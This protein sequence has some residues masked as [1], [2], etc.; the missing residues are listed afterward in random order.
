[1][2]I[3]ITW[4]SS[5]IGKHLYSG[6]KNENEVFWISRTN[7]D[8]NSFVW[9]INDYDFLDEV[10]SKVWEIDYLILNAWVWS[11]DKFENISIEKHL[12]IINTNLTSNIIFVSKI[13]KN[14]KKW[15]I[16]IWSIAGK[17]SL[18][19]GSSYA[20]SKFWLRGFAM[21]LKNEN[22]WKKIHLINPSIVHTDFHKNSWV[23]IV[24]KYSETKIE[25]ILKTVNE[26]LEKKETRFEIDL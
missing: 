25:N 10:V 7:V 3:L 26:I 6:L 14:I 19:Y 11:F 15:V 24:W 17:K 2:K 1:M 5:W 8:P 21:Q 4:N 13:L 23:E 20:A 12:Q 16:F 22:T 18:K 9:D